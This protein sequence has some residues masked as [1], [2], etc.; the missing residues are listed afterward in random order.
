MGLGGVLVIIFV[1]FF[2]IYIPVR[3]AISPLINKDSYE[4]NQDKEDSLEDLRDIGVLSPKELNATID[5][6]KKLGM[7]RVSE[8]RYNKFLKVL[9]ELRTL[10]YLDE[11]AF[12]DKADKLKKY[13][14]IN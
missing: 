6:Y 10:G 14:K 11:A 8:E 2:A 3:L 1:V 13:F 12:M 4:I 5:L 9:E 7:K